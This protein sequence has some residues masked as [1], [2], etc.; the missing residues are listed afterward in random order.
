MGAV[1]APRRI[2][3]SELGLR[4]CPRR[5]QPEGTAGPVC[6][7]ACNLLKTPE[8]YQFKNVGSIKKENVQAKQNRSLGQI[9]LKGCHSAVSGLWDNNS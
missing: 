4:T 8:I 3:Q 1:F 5:R 2:E 7:Q 6:Y 9:W